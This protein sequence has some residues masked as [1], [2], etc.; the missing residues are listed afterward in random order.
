[1][2][3]RPIQTSPAKHANI[4]RPVNPPGTSRRTPGARVPEFLEMMAYRSPG[5]GLL[6]QRNSEILPWRYFLGSEHTQ[7][8][9]MVS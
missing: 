6:Q 5:S 8:P 9:E 2:A 1:M 4:F 3:A 7:A